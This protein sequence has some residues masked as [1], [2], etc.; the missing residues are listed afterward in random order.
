[1]KF[2]ELPYYNDRKGLIDSLVVHCT[3]SENIIASFQH[4]RVSAH[5]IMDLDGNITQCVRDDKRAWH[6]GVSCWLGNRDLNSTSLGI[7]IHSPSLGQTPYTDAQIRSFINF[8]KNKMEQYDISPTMILGHSDISPDRRPD[9][10]VFFPWKEL[11]KEGIG[12]WYNL[13]DSGKTGHLSTPEALRIIGYDTET[14]EKSA[15]SAYAF[16]RRYIPQYVDI[17]PCYRDVLNQVF[18]KDK[19]RLNFFL[20][21]KAVNSVACMVAY[22]ISSVRKQEYERRPGKGINIMPF[23]PILSSKSERSK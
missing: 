12:V 21:S 7:E 16:T 9:P 1:M 3:P 6:A 20:N 2:I 17:F 15:L 18:P 11:A 23:I 8:A 13:K 10:G 22:K 19:D 14:S 4:H 5:Y